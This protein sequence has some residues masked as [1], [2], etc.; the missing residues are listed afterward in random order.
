MLNPLLTISLDLLLHLTLALGLH[1]APIRH[2]LTRLV[3][4]LLNGQQLGLER[5]R[6]TRL[7]RKLI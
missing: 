2:R 6:L 3:Q 1:T 4:L 5:L 7:H